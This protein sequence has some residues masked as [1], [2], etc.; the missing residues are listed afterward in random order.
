MVNAERRHDHV[1]IAQG[2]SRL[3]VDATFTADTETADADGWTISYRIPESG[4]PQDFDDGRPYEVTS[5]TTGDRA[6][7]LSW[8]KIGRRRLGVRIGV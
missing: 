5:A 4:A 7:F 2:D 3:E 6:R 8:R 1:V